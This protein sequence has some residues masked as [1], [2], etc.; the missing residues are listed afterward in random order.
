MITLFLCFQFTLCIGNA[1]DNKS[2][3]IG[4]YHTIKSNILESDR[5]IQVYLPSDYE[6]SDKAYPVLYILDSQWHFTNAVA[7]QHSLRLPGLLPE[8]I[9]VGIQTTNPLRRTLMGSQEDKF[10]AFLEKEVIVYADRNFRTSDERILFGWE[11]AAY[12][13]N[14]ALLNKKQLFNA[15]ILTNGAYASEKTLKEFSEMSMPEEKYLYM[16]NSDKDIYYVQSS[17]DFAEVL[18]Q[19]KPNNLIWKYQKFNDEIHESLAYVAL[20]QGLKFYYHN[21]GSL[22]FS[23]I[24]EFNKIGGMSYLENYFSDRAKR[25]GFDAKIDDSTKNSLI[26]LAWNRD[27]FESF[28]LFMEKFKDVLVTQR[29][30]SA[31]WQ[32]RFAQ[33]YLKHG[34]LDNAI[35]YFTNGINKYPEAQQQALMNSGIAKAYF[36]K[37]ET[38][39]SIAFIKKA[40]DLATEQSDSHLQ[41]YK[42]Q[43]LMY[44][45]SKNN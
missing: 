20:Y 17:N 10:L 44:Q 14:Y 36:E 45:N 43:L 4:K 18:K 21:F 22:V 19:K 23:S 5:I 33:F 13:S 24:D 7:I 38:E 11:A 31:Y 29:Y 3:E 1:Q 15:A 25:F 40:V 37:K 34:D 9:V 30:D 26:W 32:N 28:Q 2:I 6:Q 42:D 16:A 8:M 39:K 41:D 12:F 35:A 27:D